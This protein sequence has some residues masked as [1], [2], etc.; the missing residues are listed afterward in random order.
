MKGALAKL[1]TKHTNR[2]FLVEEESVFWIFRCAGIVPLQNKSYGFLWQACHQES[3]DACEVQKYRLENVVGVGYYDIKTIRHVDIT[4]YL[5][6][7]R[8]G[9]FSIP[10]AVLEKSLGKPIHLFLNQKCEAFENR[11]NNDMKYVVNEYIVSLAHKLPKPSAAKTAFFLESRE[12]VTLRSFLNEGFDPANLHI[13]NFQ[14]DIASFLTDRNPG[15]NVAQQYAGDFMKQT[16]VSFDL[17]WL[18]YCGT[19]DG[20]KDC[21]PFDDI[22]VLFQR[23]LLRDGAVFAYTFSRRNMRRLMA[24]T[25]EKRIEEYC[26]EMA[27][28]NGRSLR[29][30]KTMRYGQMFFSAFR[31]VV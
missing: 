28:C 12:E 1:R 5:K 10:K 11:R 13:A 25:D 7:Q 4:K 29:K 3:A 19:I 30:Q 21:N 15:V 31:V 18:D 23:R 8:T 16:N 26:R 22:T 2:F 24:K 14:A 9:T 17:V 27:K 20:N 6:M